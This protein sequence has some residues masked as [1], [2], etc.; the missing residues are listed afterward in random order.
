MSAHGQFQLS[1]DT[2]GEVVSTWGELT[3]NNAQFSSEIDPLR[4]PG[5]ASH[6]DC[7]FAK[8]IISAFQPFVV[9]GY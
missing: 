8:C 7:L 3:G 4:A 6:P 1:I 5:Q 9:G 2:G